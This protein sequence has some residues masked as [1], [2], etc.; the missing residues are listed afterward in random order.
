MT[1]IAIPFSFRNRRYSL[2][3]NGKCCYC[4]VKLV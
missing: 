3:N 1:A 2:W 4:H